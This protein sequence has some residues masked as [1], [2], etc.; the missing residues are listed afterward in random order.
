LISSYDVIRRSLRHMTSSDGHCVIWRHQTVIA[1]YDVI[2]RS[3]RHMTSS[4]GHCVI[5]RHQTVIA[6]YDVVRRSL[7]HMTSYDV[8]WHVKWRH[9]TS[10]YG[11]LRHLPHLGV[12]TVMS[13]NKF[14]NF[15]LI[16]IHLIMAKSGVKFNFYLFLP[17]EISRKMTQNLIN[18]NINLS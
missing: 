10:Y 8:I 18:S 15:R 17:L 16:M 1:S 4:D 5:W 13:C 6:S 14:Q 12:P 7:R 3:L 9:M 11:K 2:R